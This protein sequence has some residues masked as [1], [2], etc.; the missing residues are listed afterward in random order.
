[1]NEVHTINADKEL[2]TLKFCAINKSI[3]EADHNRV[4]N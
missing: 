4:K 2:K 1:M 3:S